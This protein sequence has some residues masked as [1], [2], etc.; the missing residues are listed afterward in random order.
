MPVDNDYVFREGPTGLEFVGDFEGLYRSEA[1][2]WHQSGE[3]AA[4]TRL[5]YSHSRVQLVKVLRRRLS[6]HGVGL[7]IGCGH[8]HVVDCLASAGVAKW[9]GMDVSPTAIKKASDLYPTHRFF[10][11]DITQPFHHFVHQYDVVVLG[12]LLWYVLHKM[13]VVVDNCF[14]LLK[15]GGF[16]VVSQ[17]YLTTPQRYGRQWAAG[18]EGAVQLFLRYPQWFQLV[19][20]HYED[21]LGLSHN[22]GLIL[23]RK[24]PDGW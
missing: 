19:E 2:P 4:A 12:Q 8:G 5:Y 9:E 13:D 18:F 7:E 16:F 17:A 14:R 11:G 24:R 10:V 22:D 6:S 21:Q 23:M 15:L 1:D 20:A 3:A